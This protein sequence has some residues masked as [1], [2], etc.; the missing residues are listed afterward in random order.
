MLGAKVLGIAYSF[1]RNESSTRTKVPGSESSWNVYSWGMKVPQELQFQGANV[2]RNESGLFAPGNESAEEWKVR[3]SFDSC[4][5]ISGILLKVGIVR[6]KI[7]SGKSC[8]KLFIVSCIFVSIQVFI[9]ST[10][11][12]WVTLNMPSAAEEC[13]EPSGNFTLSGE[14]SSCIH[15][16]LNTSF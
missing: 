2:P 15:T 6:K 14:W 5:R 16:Y 12:M 9:T 1:W 3:H 4:Q 7:L 11:M 8:L 13:H 10:G